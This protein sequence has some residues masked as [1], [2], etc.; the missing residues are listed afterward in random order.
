MGEEYCF[1]YQGLRYVGICHISI[2]CIQEKIFCKLLRLS[3]ACELQSSRR[4][5]QNAVYAAV[6]HVADLSGNKSDILEGSKCP[7]PVL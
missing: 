5:M 1:L 4:I 3:I 7:V 2:N 6:N